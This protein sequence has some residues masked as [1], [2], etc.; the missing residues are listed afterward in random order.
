M[1]LKICLWHE[2]ELGALRRQKRGWLQMEYLITT[3]CLYCLCSPF[4]YGAWVHLRARA[5]HINP[6][7]HYMLFWSILALHVWRS[8][9]RAVPTHPR[10][11]SPWSAAVQ[12]LIDSPCSKYTCSW[13]SSID[14]SPSIST[15]LQGIQMQWL[16]ATGIWGLWRWNV[17]R[18]WCIT[19]APA[20][21]SSTEFSCSNFPC[22]GGSRWRQELECF[23]WWLGYF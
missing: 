22:A 3:A 18:L 2:A 23:S 14:N 1:Y 20:S 13:P 17:L 15:A 19:I 7:T 6:S 21:P 10:V 8:V 5:S 12:V 9:E 4:P 11:F 16:W